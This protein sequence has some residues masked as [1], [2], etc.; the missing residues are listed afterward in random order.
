MEYLNLAF[1]RTSPE[2]FRVLLE[3]ARSAHPRHPD[4]RILG[5]RLHLREGQ[6]ALAEA[7]VAAILTQNPF[8]APVCHRVLAQ[9]HREQGDLAAAEQ[10]LNLA[11][12]AEAMLDRARKERRGASLSDPLEPHGCLDAQ[13]A[14]MVS[15]LETLGGLERAF[16]VRKKLAVH[17]E[18][19]V[20]LLVVSPQ[21]GWWDPWG[22]KR[23]AFQ[24]RIAR[25]CPFPG[26]AT[27]YV[28]VARPALLWRHRALFDALGALILP[29][30]GR[31]GL[32]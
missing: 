9:H 29:G 19:P 32:A 28:L 3:A 31:Q 14:P 11:C 1:D 15:Y 25:E 12:R 8:L 18:H 22:R 23:Q 4:G 20:L 17:P 26:R 24:T 21:H 10:A 7:Q 6:V 30:R 2:V 5:V 27:G 13:L 16:L